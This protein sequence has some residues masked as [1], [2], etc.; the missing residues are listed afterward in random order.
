LRVTPR[1]RNVCTVERPA[2]ARA[3]RSPARRRIVQGEP[4]FEVLDAD[5]DAH[6]LVAELQQDRFAGSLQPLGREAGFDSPISS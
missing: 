3:A 4:L 5:Q 6:R 2:F 1:S